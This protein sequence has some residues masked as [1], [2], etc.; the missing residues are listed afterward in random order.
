MV[1]ELL[2]KYWSI[3]LRKFALMVVCSR[4]DFSRTLRISSASA[5]KVMFF[6]LDFSCFITIIVCTIIV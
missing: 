3:H 4:L 5:L 2:F 1:L 6:N